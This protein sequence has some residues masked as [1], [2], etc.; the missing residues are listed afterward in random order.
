MKRRTAFVANSSSSSFLIFGVERKVF[1]EVFPNCVDPY[2]MDL[3][4]IEDVVGYSLFYTDEGS[5]DNDSFVKAV[6][7][8]KTNLES[9]GITGGKFYYG[10]QY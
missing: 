5:N 10:V 6:T 2:D 4:V 3:D 7:N 8:V 9:K 1:D